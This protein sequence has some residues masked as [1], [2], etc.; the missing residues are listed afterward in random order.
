MVE[1]QRE[2]ERE[3]R[4]KEIILFLESQWLEEWAHLLFQKVLAQVL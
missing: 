2:R 3:G 1:N 4:V